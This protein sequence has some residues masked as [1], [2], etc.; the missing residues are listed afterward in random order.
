MKLLFDQ[1][2]SHRLVARLTSDFPGCQHVRDVG[3]KDADDAT[4]W[5][6][7]Q[8]ND[9]IIVSKDTDFEQ[10]ALLHGHPPKTVWLRVGNANTNAIEQLL[11]SRASELL[12]FHSDPHVA[13][14]ALS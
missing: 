8:L 12:A 5:R 6:F 7:A 3:L 9:F 13:L 11:R 4:I 2:L 1:N 10:R 14:M